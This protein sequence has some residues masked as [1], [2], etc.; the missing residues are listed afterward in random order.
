V[1]VVYLLTIGF[2]TRLAYYWHKVEEKK[3][4]SKASCCN[5]TPCLLSSFSIPSYQLT[6]IAVDGGNP[7]LSGTVIVLV[8]VLD[9]NDNSPTF[10]D[11]AFETRVPEDASPGTVVFRASAADVDLGSNAHLRYG[12]TD[13]TM[14]RHGDVFGVRTETGAVYTRRQLDYEQQRDYTLY[15]TASDR[16]D[17]EADSSSSLTGMTSIIVRVIDVNDNAPVIRFNFRKRTVSTSVVDGRKSDTDDGGDDDG[18]NVTTDG[19][20]SSSTATRRT[21]RSSPT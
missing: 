2:F 15:V 5:L 7:P 12:F 21:E 17:L 19:V 10:A 11:V 13:E 3:E 16:A 8:S 1:I 14:A 9:V 6:I 4:L 20:R 18:V